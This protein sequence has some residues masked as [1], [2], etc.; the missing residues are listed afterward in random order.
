MSHI[1]GIGGIFFKSPDPKA[2]SNWYASTFDLNPSEY[3]GIEFQWS[4]S[5]QSTQARYSIWTPFK[6]N[7]T[8]L[9]PSTKS[10]MI[11]F[12][13]DDLDALLADLEQKGVKIEPERD[14]ADYGKFAWLM[15]PDGNKIELWQPP[16]KQ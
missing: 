14:N 16:E 12:I 2:L 1:K 5:A 7:T 11:N 6:E 10:F 15:D 4:D 9:N 3:G 13:V 8:Y